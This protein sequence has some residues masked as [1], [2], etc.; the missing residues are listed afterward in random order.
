M[1]LQVPLK[2]DG[3]TSAWTKTEIDKAVEVEAQMANQVRSHNAMERGGRG[4]QRGEGN[5]RE[6]NRAVAFFGTAVVG[7]PCEG[8]RGG[9]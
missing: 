6:K 9:P 8:R 3:K 4:W 1:A 2:V 5:R 7:L